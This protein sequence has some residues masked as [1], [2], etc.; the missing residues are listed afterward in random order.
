MNK[1]VFPDVIASGASTSSG[2]NLLT[3][4]RNIQLQ[5]PTFSTA[6]Q[7]ALQ[8]SID[9]GTT[10]YNVYQFLN[11]STVGANAFNIVSAVAAGGGVIRLPDGLN[12]IRLV[13]TGTV[14]NGVSFKVIC[15]D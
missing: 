6:A 10:F 3:G 5:V 9:G 4:Y 11:S 2:V 15:S 13:A 7:L 8:N 14:G 12:H 1:S